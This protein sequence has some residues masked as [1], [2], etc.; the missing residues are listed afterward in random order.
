[1]IQGSWESVQPS[2]MP[3]EEEVHLLPLIGLRH[4]CIC[5]LSSL[6]LTH[7][8]VFSSL[9]TTAASLSYFSLD[10]SSPFL[11]S[12]HPSIHP[13]DSDIITV[14]N[15]FCRLRHVLLE[16]HI[17]GSLFGL[18]II[19]SRGLWTTSFLPSFILHGWVNL[20]SL[21]SVT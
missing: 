8:S 19:C 14:P 7:S 4:I 20:L 2:T 10:G 13:A 6:S 17:D 12:L 16:E 15:F 3:E 11:P 18:A 21:G 5:H 9:R 1:M